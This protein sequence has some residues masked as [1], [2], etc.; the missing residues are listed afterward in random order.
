MAVL[1]KLLLAIFFIQVVLIAFG[2]ADMPG[3]GLYNFISNPSDWRSG[4][5]MILSDLILSAG[6]VAIVIGTFFVKSDLALFS[7]MAAILYTFG[8]PLGVLWTLI[9]DQ[10]SALIANLFISPIIL[11]YIFTVIAW[12]RG[13]D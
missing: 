11:L 13:Q 4:F 5:S 3:E 1:P 8:K 6:G 10:S 7:G 2:I 12:W 9:A